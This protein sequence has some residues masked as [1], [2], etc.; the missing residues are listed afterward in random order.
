MFAD[1][2]VPQL[3]QLPEPAVPSWLKVPAHWPAQA[4]LLDFCQHMGP[5]MA[6]L[7]ILLGVIY[8]LFGYKLFKAL[9]L[10]NSAAVG[11]AVGFVIG[12]KSEMCLPLMVLG[13]FIAATITWPLMK[14]AV[15]I[16][17]GVAGALIGAS[18]W[19]TFNLDP[20]FAWA[21]AMI[22]LVLFGLLSFILF[23]GSVM[24]YMSLQGAVM[25]IFGL[26]GM[27]FKYQDVA[28][29]VSQTML[30]KTFLLPMGLFI[31]TVIGMIYQQANAAAPG[32]P[33]K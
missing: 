12:Q 14:W 8:L 20:Q 27:V 23:R 31:T 11:A 4:D 24:M 18:A 15:A 3:P 16:T 17:G 5:G 26:L 30:T 25:L 33:K 28:P 9:V 6:A 1:A 10:L 13:G 19:H 2:V 29:K 22:G 21:G 32:P 7:L